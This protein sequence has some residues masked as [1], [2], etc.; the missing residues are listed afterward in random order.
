MC[1]RIKGRVRGVE[2]VRVYASGETRAIA[3]AKVMGLSVALA[4]RLRW[5]D[6]GRV[7]QA[8]VYKL[9]AAEA[10]AFYAEADDDD[11]GG[12]GDGGGGDDDG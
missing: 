12:G 4:T 8:R 5:S 6:D 3:R 10:D 9:S 7:V 11:G 1:A 2:P